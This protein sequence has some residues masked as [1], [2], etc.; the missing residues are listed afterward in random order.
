VISR[1]GMRNPAHDI[2]FEPVRIGPKT[3]KY[4]FF[5]TP[6]CNGFAHLPQTHAH[7]R[8]MKAE[9]GWAGISTE[10]CSIAPES[11]V[12]PHIGPRLWDEDD[13]RA[14]AVMCDAIHSEDAL[15]A[16]ELSFN[17]HAPAYETRT[18]NRGVTSV[19]PWVPAMRGAY[20]MDRR[21]IRE[22]Q[23]FYVDA[24]DR[25]RRAGFDIVTF[26]ATH[27][28]SI[29]HR[30]LIPFFNSRTDEYGGPL[31]NRA[32]FLLETLE[33]IR[34]RIGDE[35]AVACRLGVD[36]L[37]EPYGLPRGLHVEEDGIGTVELADHLVDYWDVVVAYLPQ[38]GEDAA[39]SRT[40]PENHEAAIVGQIKPH[41]SKPVV[42]VGRF[43]NPD[44]M[45]AAIRSGQCDIIG[46]ARPSISDPFLPRKIEEGRYE[47]IRECIGCNVCISRYEVGGPIV[48]TQNATTGEEYRRGWHPE[49]FSRAENAD[50]DVLVVGAGPAGMECARVLGERGMR[51]VHLVEAGG[52]PGG[53]L[54][55]ITKL[56]GLGEWGR[57][58][59]YRQVQLAKLKNVEVILGAELDAEAVLNYGAEIVVLAT[60]ARWRHDGLNSLTHAPIPTAEGAWVVT[61]EQVVLEGVRPEYHAVVYDA[62][63]YFLGGSIAET[64]ALDRSRVTVVTP[65]ATLGPYMAYT[66]EL[67]RFNRELRDRGVEVITDHTLERIE[68]GYVELAHAWTD[69]RPRVAC[70]LVILVTTRRQ[71]DGL[72]RGLQDADFPV[73]RIGDCLAPGTIADSVFSG[74]RLAREIDSPDPRIPLPFIRERATVPDRVAVS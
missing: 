19:G 31:E 37:A 29:P 70:D 45:A 9:G 40:H 63:G 51:R 68:T 36:T 34:E 65:F 1:P 64:L 21:E 57:V 14:L 53:C 48:C 72:W 67:W 28:S 27:A 23:Q 74:H 56:P 62:D 25:G 43:T 6:Q 8:L 26:Q 50:N 32:R 55:W 59:N 4:R 2:L 66:L 12:T 7:H 39:P 17:W 42:N 46:A 30:F 3:L 13:V 5:Q 16:V 47:D 22:L 24:A 60:G 35:C 10:Y 73:Y 54:N 69:A 58:T 49:R 52:E 38:W 15:A 18:A 44:T 41:T 33:L 11:D 20:E 71:N 61:P